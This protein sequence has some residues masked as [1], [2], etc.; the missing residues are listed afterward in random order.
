MCAADAAL[1]MNSSRKRACVCVIIFTAYGV[2]HEHA[3]LWLQF[4]LT[5]EGA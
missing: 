2:I 4:R 1:V 3:H 5:P